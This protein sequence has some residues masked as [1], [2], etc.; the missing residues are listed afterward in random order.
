MNT[1]KNRIHKISLLI[2]TVIQITFFPFTTYATVVDEAPVEQTPETTIPATEPIVEAAPATEPKTG[3]SEPTGVQQPTGADSTKYTLNEETGNWESEKYIWN[4]TTHET[5]SKQPTEYSFN[6]ESGL[7]E[8][9]VWEYDAPSGTYVPRVVALDSAD[10]QAGS[11]TGPFSNN[12]L[13]S[14]SNNS[15]DIDS[16]SDASVLNELRSCSNSGDASVSKN[17]NG[18]NASTGS[19]YTMANILNLLGSNWGN[20]GT[21][22]NTFI[23]DINGDV[24]GDIYVNPENTG[25]NSN[26][27]SNQTRNNNLDV[28]VQEDGSIQ[29]NINLCARSG[30]A[31]V[32]SNTNGGNAT[33]GNADAVAN[34][35]NLI[36]SSISSG[37]SFLG[38]MNINGNLDGDILLPDYLR[39]DNLISPTT[40]PNALFNGTEIENSE[41]IANLI[42][43]SEIENTVETEAKSGD[44]KVFNN[45]TAGSASTGDAQTDVTLM[46]LTGREIVGKNGLLVFVNVLGTWVG[47]IVDSPQGAHTA[48][49]GS[50]INSNTTHTAVEN[51]TATI[52]LQRNNRITNNVNVVAESGDAKVYNN[53]NAGHAKSGNAT[54]SANI[55]NLIDSKL[56]LSDWF[57]I[58]FINV[59]GS[60]HGSFGVDTSNGNIAALQ[61]IIETGEVPVQD[62]R[63]FA[64]VPSDINKTRLND[65]TP[66]FANP[67]PPEE[68]QPVA[69]LASAE[70]LGASSVIPQNARQRE[71]YNQV[72]DRM[73]NILSFGSI[74]TLSYFGLDQ[75]ARFS[76]RK[77]GM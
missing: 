52:D 16:N 31:R 39:I 50:G 14:A 56:S 61:Q 63:V 29:N 70:V 42:S 19:A 26:T 11:T 9:T 21:D 27:T 6:K 4:P 55:L 30:S 28:I 36:N 38:I 12:Q 48:A 57:G 45:N 47:F 67:E 22:V 17:T 23:T 72:I 7:W 37:N 49:L 43:T 54:A 24:R 44:A 10:L 75:L 73:L 20:L 8:T 3:P 53:T 32:H 13:N 46:N 71:Q 2:V 1:I 40:G 59:F 33:S 41:L 35:L 51:N 65:I 58:L 77:R 68:Q 60:W 34:I 66:S 74:A 76:R 62:A 18:G 25:P 64:F 15:I 5:T 69:T